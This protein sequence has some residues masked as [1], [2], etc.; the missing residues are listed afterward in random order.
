MLLER[1]VQTRPGPV[2]VLCVCRNARC[3]QEEI[4]EVT[5]AI[6]EELETSGLR[7][8]LK[9]QIAAARLAPGTPGIGPVSESTIVEELR[10]KKLELTG[11]AAK[12]V[13][14][15]ANYDSPDS[16]VMEYLSVNDKDAYD[17]WTRVATLRDHKARLW[18]RL[19]EEERVMEVAFQGNSNIPAMKEALDAY[20]S[21][22]LPKNPKGASV[23]S[24]MRS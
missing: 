1:S 10:K 24:C 12:M 9:A 15:M 13:E 16:T 11:I 19:R 7:K 8:Q 5:E 22:K 2:V 18:T 6:A 4:Q 17:A 23:A 3:H 14:H 21:D 20:M